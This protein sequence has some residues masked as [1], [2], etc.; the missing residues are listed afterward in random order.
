MGCTVSFNRTHPTN[1]RTT[2]VLEDNIAVVE[3]ILNE[4]AEVKRQQ[5]MEQQVMFEL[6]NIER[7]TSSI[8]ANR[9]YFKG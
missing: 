5:M 6:F 2:A 4:Q 7:K 8:H 9:D 1:L 3:K